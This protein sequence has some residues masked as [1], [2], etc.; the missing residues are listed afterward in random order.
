MIFTRRETKEGG[1]IYPHLVTCQIPQPA[2]FLHPQKSREKER[3]H[4][5]RITKAENVVENS[6]IF[7]FVNKMCTFV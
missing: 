2:A 3:T 1:Y 6:A 4:K 7:H 5:A